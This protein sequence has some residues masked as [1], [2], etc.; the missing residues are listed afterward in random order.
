MMRRVAVAG[1]FF[2][3]A[4]RVGVRNLPDG[5][6]DKAFTRAQLDRLGIGQELRTIPWGSKRPK[7]PPSTLMA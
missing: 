3:Y 2:A 5:L 4:Y 1:T 6:N 7:L